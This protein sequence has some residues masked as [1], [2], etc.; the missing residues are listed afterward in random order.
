MLALDSVD[1]LAKEEGSRQALGALLEYAR[2]GGGPLGMLSVLARY[3]MLV[4]CGWVERAI[5]RWA[6]HELRRAVV[7]LLFNQP[8]CL[9]GRQAGRQATQA[10]RAQ[11]AGAAM[12]GDIT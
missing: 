2:C 11:P 4:W 10:L 6:L 9:P 5:A 1:R 8:A 3:G 12:S 7:L